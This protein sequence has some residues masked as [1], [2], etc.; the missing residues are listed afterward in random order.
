MRVAGL[1]S[2]GKDSIWNLHYCKHFGHDIVCVAN[3][4][5]PQ[6]V[7]EM[8]SYMYQTVGHDVIDAVAGA[9]QLPLVRRI[10]DG[11]PQSTHSNSYKPQEG[12]EVE[13]LLYLLQ[14]VLAAHPDVQAV[15]VGAILSNY[16]RLRVESVCSRLGLQVL[17][18]MW[19]QDQTHLMQQM[20]GSGLDARIV[21][22]A[23]MGLEEKHVGRSILDPIF[24]QHLFDIGQRWGVHVCGEGGEYETTVFDAPL[25]HYALQPS[26]CETVR[27]EDG[28]DVAFLVTSEVATTVVAERP[29]GPRFDLLKE[30]SNLC[31][32]ADTFPPQLGSRSSTDAA[33]CPAKVS[34]PPAAAAGAPRLS[35]QGPL[36][37]T[38]SLDANI[39]GVALGGSVQ[40]QT[41]SVLEAAG[42]WLQA[43]GISLQLAIHVELQ[44]ADMGQFAEV[45]RVYAGFFGFEAPSRVCVETTL[46]IG[47]HLRFRLMLRDAGGAASSDL[48]TL[49]VQSI[50]T[51]AM[52]CIGPYSQAMRLSNA[53]L[54]AGVIGLVPH[55]MTLVDPDNM[56]APFQMRPDGTALAKWEAE[57]W[58]LMRS[59]NNVLQEMKNGFGRVLHACVYVVGLRCMEHIE[60][61]VLAYMRREDSASQPLI[62][63][64]EVPRLPKDAC[65]EIN[66]VCDHNPHTDAE[67][68]ESDRPAKLEVYAASVPSSFSP[69]AV[70]DA[71]VAS[72]RQTCS[73]ARPEG[74][75]VLVLYLSQFDESL[76]S[77]V[78]EQ[79]LSELG[80]S[81]RYAVSYMPATFLGEAVAVRTI[82][83]S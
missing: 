75:G 1:V 12:D 36:L 47:L 56:P 60:A 54:T 42:A 7:H 34:R 49:R 50:S 79:T 67:D 43:Q 53:L 65:I 14:D 26:A 25:Y 40:E 33:H 15:S 11:R 77:Q 58:I 37:V 66:L 13:D 38:S 35:R 52:A 4:A 62:T 9:L 61:A 10:I 21:K 64:L 74:A 24:S 63:V 30:Y 55:C 23:S 32:Y 73:S 81:E 3:L 27:H 8:D 78:V 20:I 29:A 6:G 28:A 48:D 76:I 45:N 80:R 16:Q 72:I 5:P 17:C 44:V 83:T 59:L 31:Y 41:G 69:E 71:V 70:S 19:M 51:W 82:V 57:L 46:P 18:F 68:P 2:G 22:V 39:L